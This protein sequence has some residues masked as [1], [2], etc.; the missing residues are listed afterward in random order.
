MA[1]REATVLWS[2]DAIADLDDIWLYYFQTAGPET[3]ENV[4]RHIYERIDTIGAY[5]LVGR[6]RDD[7]QAGYRS[8]PAAPHV[9]FYRIGNDLPELLRVLDGR[10]DIEAELLP[11]TLNDS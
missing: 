2:A 11:S 1:R 9:I 6:A 4:V 7:I 3:A 5:P 10:Q 8:Y